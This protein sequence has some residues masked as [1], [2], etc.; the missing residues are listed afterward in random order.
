MRLIGI[1]QELF[2]LWKQFRCSLYLTIDDDYHQQEMIQIHQNSDWLCR[3]IENDSREIIGLVE[4]SFRNIVDGCLSS[5]VAYLEGLYLTEAE[6]GKGHGKQAIDLICQW[7]VENG[8]SE[9]ATDT[10]S[11][12]T[13]AQLF[14][15][16]LGFKEIDRVVE[17]RLELSPPAISTPLYSKD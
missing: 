3:F 11:G 7:C 2:P 8:F 6:R 16:R 4:I 1:K 9:L 12:N 17:Y 14:Y 5:P 13:K 10:Q 15:T